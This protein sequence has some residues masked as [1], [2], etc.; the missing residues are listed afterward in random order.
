MWLFPPDL[1]CGLEIDAWFFFF[2]KNERLWPKG[3]G[4]YYLDFKW[5]ENR[6]R[7]NEIWHYMLTSKAVIKLSSVIR[8][9]SNNF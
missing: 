6:Q 2:D 4:R 1:V 7:E 5:N 3:K 8:H 9:D